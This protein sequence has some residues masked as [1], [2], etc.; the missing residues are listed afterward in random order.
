M[1]ASRI[2]HKG[3]CDHA[4]TPYARRKCRKAMIVEAA[5]IAADRESARQTRLTE[6]GMSETDVI[7]WYSEAADQVA[8]LDGDGRDRRAAYW[9]RELATARQA[10]ADLG[11]T[12]ASRPRRFARA[13]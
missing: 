7:D 2:R 3:I 13:A 9:Q 11:L 10:M 1:I 4:Q 12:T 8:M 5:R 6:L